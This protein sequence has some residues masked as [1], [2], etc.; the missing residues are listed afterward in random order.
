MGSKYFDNAA[1]TRT[2]EEVL[3]TMM[4]YYKL[5][6]GNPSS[7][8]TIGRNAKMAIEEARKKV[9]ILLNSK[10][11]EIY[12]TG[13]GSESNNTALKGIAHKNKE[14]GNHIITSKI[15]HPSILNTCKEL[16]K[17]GFNITYLNVNSE[18]I[19]DLNQLKSSINAKTILISIMFANNEIGTIEPIEEISKIAKERGIIL[20]VDAV[21]A[22]GNINIDVENM[23]IDLLSLS[24]H[25]LYGPKGIGALYI[26]EGIEIESLIKG[27][28][29]EKGIRAGTEN[30]AGIVGLGKACELAKENL[31]THIRYLKKMRDYYISEIERK[32]PSVSLNGSREERLPGNANFS[33]EGVEGNSVL[34]KLDELGI[35]ISSGS[36]CSTGNTNPS[37][38]LTAIGL[39]EKTSKSALRTTF[40]EDN[41]IE[42]IDYLVNN[43]ERIIYEFRKSSDI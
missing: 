27:G 3:K 26:K 23:G 41:T 21:Q 20:H 14:K 7:A 22:C 31:N 5:Q 29:Q 15:E 9:A 8:Y 24:G 17:E 19:V 6:F 13:G 35:C 11:K 4:P 38:V 12:F 25:K 16:E 36:A 40:G 28:H 32:I 39:D 37:H 42:D 34:L 30:V 18:G 43:L 1:T 33:F 2:K 10:N